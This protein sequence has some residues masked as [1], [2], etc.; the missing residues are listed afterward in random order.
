M[1]IKV[2]FYSLQFTHKLFIY[3][4]TSCSIYYYICSEA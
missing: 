2:I 1:R 4:Q 3:V